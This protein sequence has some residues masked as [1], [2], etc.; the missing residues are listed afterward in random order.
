MKLVMIEMMGGTKSFVGTL[1]EYDGDPARHYLTECVEIKEIIAPGPQGPM[2]Y[3]IG[4][5]IGTMQD[6]TRNAPL[7]FD[8]DNTSPH[9][10]CYNT[11]MNAAIDK[12]T[13]AEMLHYGKAGSA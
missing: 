7:V 10:S 8:L 2:V 11:T 3:H 9:M 13:G 5:K 4:I 12:P 1:K 6:V